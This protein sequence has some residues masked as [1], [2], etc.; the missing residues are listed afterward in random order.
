L[1]GPL[2]APPAEITN[3]PDEHD[4][5]HSHQK[6]IEYFS[7]DSVVC[8]VTQMGTVLGLLELLDVWC[9][10]WVELAR[11]SHA[12]SEVYIWERSI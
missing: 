11:C 3:R 8:K 6:N 10:P 9:S 2:A 7:S 1:L 12:I 4:Y 5:H